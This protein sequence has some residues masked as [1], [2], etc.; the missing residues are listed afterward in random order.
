MLLGV[1]AVELTAD[2]N[3]VA[4]VRLGTIEHAQLVVRLG[5]HA[6]ERR[7]HALVGD[8]ARGEA[9]GG[10]VQRHAHGDHLALRIGGRDGE[11]DVSEEDVGL[12]GRAHLGLC[13]AG[14]PE[15]RRQPA[16]EGE[17]RERASAETARLRRMN[18]VAR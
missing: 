3:R 18:F 17:E 15:C 8:R 12:V 1:L 10:V 7:E 14:L 4:H 6:V 16:R 2:A 13:A 11:Q 5:Q 9:R